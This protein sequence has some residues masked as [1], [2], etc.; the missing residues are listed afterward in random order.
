MEAIRHLVRRD[1]RSGNSVAL[2]V[3]VNIGSVTGVSRLYVSW[4][5][6]CRVGVSI[7]TA[8]DLDL[9]ARDVK[10]RGRSC[11]E[12]KYHLKAWQAR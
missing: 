1:L 9:S 12:C 11:I 5:L 10:L 6:D 8:G 2:E 3:V 4:D 7:S